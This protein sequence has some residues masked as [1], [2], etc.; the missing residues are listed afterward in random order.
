MISERNSSS[1]YS[2][3]GTSILAPNEVFPMP[4]SKCSDCFDVLFW[5]FFDSAASF[6]YV[7]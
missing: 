3:D 1:T 2:S 7:S 6:R 5:I 4:D